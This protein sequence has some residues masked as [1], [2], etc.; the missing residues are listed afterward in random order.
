MPRMIDRTIPAK[1][2][3]FVLAGLLAFFTLAGFSHSKA[4][5]AEAAGATLSLPGATCSGS[6]ASVNFSWAPVAGATQTFLDLSV[7]DGTFSSAGS[8][9][10]GYPVSGGSFNHPN[11]QAGAIHWWRINSMVSGSWQTSAVNAFV[12]CGDPSLL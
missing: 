8:T 7:Q 11:L 9:F 2:G 6:T 1:F 12:P 3:L 5:V 10:F 4:G